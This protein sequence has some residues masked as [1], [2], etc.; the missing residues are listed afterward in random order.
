MS[1]TSSIFVLAKNVHFLTYLKYY[2]SWSIK[3]E[4]YIAAAH[5]ILI[6]EYICEFC[7]LQFQ[8][9]AEGRR[10]QKTWQSLENSRGKKRERESGEQTEK[11]M[12]N[13]AEW[14]RKSQATDLIN[15]N[16]DCTNWR[17]VFASV[18]QYGTQKLNKCLSDRSAFSRQLKRSPFMKT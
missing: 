3:S 2:Y 18:S 15:D 13:L 14:R 12:N 17:S 1:N 4:I 5:L 6:Q 10:C 7:L 11:Y 8:I 9:S 16:K